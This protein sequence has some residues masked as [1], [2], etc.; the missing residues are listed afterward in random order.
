ML[1][2]V[3]FRLTYLLQT[4]QLG[5]FIIACSQH[6][7]VFV[8]RSL[9]ACGL[10]CA[11]CA[12]SALVATPYAFAAS[13]SEQELAQL[14]TRA[15]EIKSSIDKLQTELNAVIQQYNEAVD[16]R[17]N[18]A[19]AMREAKVR[20]QTAQEKMAKLQEQIEAMTT[21]MYKGDK[22]GTTSNYMNVLLGAATFTDFM[23][24]LDMM[25]RV[26]E[27]HTQLIEEARA[28]KAEAEAAQ[29]ELTKQKAEAD[30]AYKIAKERKAQIAEKQGYLSQ[31]A[32]KV[33]G[34]IVEK[35]EDIEL[36][37]EAARKAEEAAKAAAAAFAASM[38]ASGNK[39]VGS[40][41][42]A[43]PCPAAK[44]SSGYGWRV[45]FGAA[46]F[47]Q[48]ADM[49]APMGSPVYAGEAGTVI[50]VANDNGY[51]GGA[52]NYVTIAH[53]NGL[54]TKYFHNSAVFVKVGDRV[55]RGQ[56]IA[57]VGSTGRSTGPHLHFQVEINGV[58]VCPYDYL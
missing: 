37:A 35:E 45:I 28:V 18:A 11:L 7:G 30:R 2:G 27:S 3:E 21:L 36:E 44:E 14:K 56:N 43:N 46:Q 19:K 26:N 32:T 49:A 17:H 53:G 33:A 52:G 48:G 31:E 29:E 34:E 23:T 47:H 6:K 57:A 4:Q 12:S 25:A 8:V 51:N 15:D 50:K 58:V 16:A 39:N 38:Q 55:E 1:L 22:S 54:V 5:S 42:F 10:A 40:G 9:I 24:G 13:E 41:F 20:I